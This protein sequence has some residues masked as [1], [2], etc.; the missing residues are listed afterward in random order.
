MSTH[1][2][3]ADLE[4]E[5][6]GVRAELRRLNG[7]P[8]VVDPDMFRHRILELRGHERLLVAELERRELERLREPV[9]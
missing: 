9:L 5:L 3:V 7:W 2:T 1:V 8:L 4:E 6:A